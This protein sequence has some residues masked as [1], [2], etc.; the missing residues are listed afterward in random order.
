[1]TVANNRN[2]TTQTGDGATLTFTFN[3]KVANA[4]MVEVYT[5]TTGADPVLKTQGGD[6]A[7]STIYTTTEGGEITFVTAPASG[8]QVIIRRKTDFL[9]GTALP[10]GQLDERALEAALDKITFSLQDL[11]Q[12]VDRAPQVPYGSTTA[13]T[14]RI[15]G[16][17]VDGGT[18]R[19]QVNGSGQI[20]GWEFT[21][22]IDDAASAAA[23]AAASAAAAAA[24]A[25]AAAAFY[26]A[27]I[28]VD[29]FGAVGDGSTDDTTAI[30]DA[31]DALADAG[32][33]RKAIIFG[34]G[35]T[36]AATNLTIPSTSNITILG[37]RATLKCI[38]GGST[39]YFVA[40]AKWVANTA[41]AQE[42]IK[43]YD[44]NIN[45]NSV[46]NHAYIHQCWNSDIVGC[47]FYGAAAGDG[48]RITAQTADGTDFSSST[49]VNNRIHSC[50]MC[51]NAGGAGLRCFDPNNRNK[52]TDAHVFN[53]FM[54]GNGTYGIYLDASAG[55]N[56]YG[57]HT[58][59]NTTGGMGV[60][61]GGT[62]FQ[63]HD[64]Y[65]EEALGL[66]IN[67][68]LVAVTVRS[69]FFNGK[70][71]AD[72]TGSMTQMLSIGNQFRTSNGVILHNY[73][74]TSKRIISIG[75]VFEA[76]QPFTW[77]NSSSTGVI[78][79]YGSYS[80]GSGRVYEGIQRTSG[81]FIPRTVGWA[82]AAP[83]TGTYTAGEVIMNTANTAGQPMGWICSSGGTPGTWR[84][85]GHRTIDATTT[86]DP[87][88]IAD[89]DGETKSLTVTGAALGDFVQV[90]APYDL[91]DLQATA[92]VQ[93]ADTVEIR[94]D[95]N[96][97][98]AVDL[99]SGTW[100]VRVTKSV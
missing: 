87:A 5:K 89:G 54:Y 26:D 27:Y 23:A 90:A 15:T 65:F 63:V 30:Q 11:N 60:N 39:D 16:T 57:N 82:S 93:A 9:Q 86:W 4:S 79:A 46:A 95:N 41:E 97:G 7:V 3:F 96:T 69:N 62:G 43:M 12:R 53:C 33:G 20:T 94:L 70:L 72:F 19:V 92:Y 99:A 100:K 17:A 91:Q 49:L 18:I 8:V 51:N 25:A 83:T 35:K 81:S 36:Y 34:P 38:S 98:G 67:D 37:N 75:D 31:L 32:D 1:M 76:S 59:S 14:P 13:L 24:S 47:S 88:S 48:L 74:A 77:S 64:N 10:I 45:A 28:Y 21:G 68:S 61:L 50:I 40:S 80:S 6:Y 58:Y 56:V 66:R 2:E 71:Q 78:I 73:F 55:W 52:A 42:P 29:E 44:L 85:W 84:E 22:N